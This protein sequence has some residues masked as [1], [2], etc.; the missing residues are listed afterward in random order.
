MWDIIK[1]YVP[2]GI[3]VAAGFVLAWQ[4][5]DPAPPRT[6]TI[7]TGAED[8]AYSAAAREYRKILAEAGV[9]LRIRPTAGSVENLKLLNDPASGIDIAFIQSGAGDPFGAPDLTSLASVFLEPLWVFVRTDRAPERLTGLKG[10]KIAIGPE[11]SG[12]RVLARTLLVASGVDGENSTFLSMSGADAARALEA[13]EVDAAFFV[14]ARVS[15]TMQ[16]LMRNPQMRLLNFAR[17][18]AYKATFSYL[19]RVNVP[20]GALALD[21]NIPAAP[22]TLV[23]PTAA[24]VGRND[25]HP[26][27]VDLILG[28]AT[29]VHRGGDLFS[30][31]G[32]FP[33]PDRVD[34][35]LNEDARRFFKS[36]PTFLRR[37]LPFGLAVMAERLLIMLVPLI[38]ILVP[39]M[40]FAPSAYK[41]NIERKIHHW[42]RE[43]RRLEARFQADDSPE[44]RTE[45]GLQ[46]DN[47]QREVGKISV[48]LSYAE[49][50]YQLRTHIAFMRQYIRT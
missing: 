2:V 17:A 42:Y 44:T 25:L 11:G 20:E 41:W 15:E 36:G 24:L 34:F 18:D 48:P 8:G 37:L 50:L 47:M 45:L 5:V 33:S 13:G 32:T 23:A 30:P 6:V 40:K 4:F 35:P 31:L 12:T 1:I 46:L 43:L 28:A 49:H 38:T 39:L 10:R 26:A 19:A 3:L 22:L 29:R 7:A 21:T 16:R 27:I 14:G 9:N